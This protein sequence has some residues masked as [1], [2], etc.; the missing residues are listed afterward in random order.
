MPKN[1]NRRNGRRTF[2]TRRGGGGR[3]PSFTHVLTAALQLSVTAPTLVAQFNVLVNTLGGFPQLASFFEM[4]QPVRYRLRPSYTNWSG[5]LAFVPGNPAFVDLPTV[6]NIDASS[7]L[8]C[9]GSVRMQ[10]GYNNTGSWCTFPYASIGLQCH[11]AITTTPA[12]G[13]VLAYNDQPG[14]ITTTWTVQAVIEVD[15]RFFRRNLNLYTITPTL[16][17]NV[18]LLNGLSEEKGADDDAPTDLSV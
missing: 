9:R 5:S 4:Y 3:D 14:S 15:V 12:A 6:G 17:S 11:T 1:Q 16:S 7:V 10:S 2:K 8:E 18:V 13:Y